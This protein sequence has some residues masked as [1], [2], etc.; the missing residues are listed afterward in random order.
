MSDSKLAFYDFSGGINTS[1]TDVMLGYGAK[2]LN[3]DDSYN[4]ELYKNQGVE[5][6]LG[7]QIYIDSDIE[8][9]SAIIGL[10]EYPKATD[11][12]LYARADGKIKYFDYIRKTTSTIHD[13]EKTITS[14]N[15]TQF[16]D[17]IAFFCTRLRRLL[18]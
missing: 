14:V 2:K 1:S 18:L 10:C 13:Y 3:W 15:F 9:N 16:L 8:D 7:N 11:G 17:G 5:R 6:M 4:V 12:F